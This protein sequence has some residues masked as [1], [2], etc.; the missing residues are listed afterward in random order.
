MLFARTQRRGAGGSWRRRSSPKDHHQAVGS[1]LTGSRACCLCSRSSS[2]PA[3]NKK[4][5]TTTS[6]LAPVAIVCLFQCTAWFTGRASDHAG[7]KTW[8]ASTS[9]ASRA[10]KRCI[11][12]PCNA[13]TTGVKTQRGETT[14]RSKSHHH[15][16]ETALDP[17]DELPARRLDAVTPDPS[18]HESGAPKRLPGRGAR[19]ISKADARRLKRQAPG[20]QKAR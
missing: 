7:G 16:V 8:P 2:L 17:R 4:R 13:A 19:S 14:G 11:G 10:A 15:V 9:S 5:N 3:A 18:T 12:N 6:L 20:L 1:I